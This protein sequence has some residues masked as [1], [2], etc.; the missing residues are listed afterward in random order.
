MHI[1]NIFMYIAVF[2]L[3]V[4]VLNFIMIAYY[5]SLKRKQIKM[6]RQSEEYIYYLYPKNLERLF[7]RQLFDKIKFDANK[8]N[9]SATER[10]EQILQG[11]YQINK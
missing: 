2:I 8:L 7:S 3:L 5:V 4:V 11:Y 9:I 6:L 10:M 1:F